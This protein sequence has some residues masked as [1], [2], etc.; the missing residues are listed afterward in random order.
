MRRS[1][2][3]VPETPI[4]EQMMYGA[5]RPSKRPRDVSTSLEETI[6][7]IQT[8]MDTLQDSVG[9]LQEGIYNLNYR[10]DQVNERLYNIEEALRIPSE[11]AF[12]AEEYAQRQTPTSQEV[13]S[14]L[15]RMQGQQASVPSP[16]ALGTPLSEGIISTSPYVEMLPSEPR[17]P[18]TPLTQKTPEYP[19]SPQSFFYPRPSP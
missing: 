10:I 12:E 2:I 5:Q 6:E 3:I 15:E 11:A 16:F 8:F 4:Q 13:R 17:T 14:A 19:T 9:K 7:D 1:Q 18:V